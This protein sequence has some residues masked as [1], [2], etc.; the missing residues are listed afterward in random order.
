MATK[1]DYYEVLGVSRDATE[2]P[3]NIFALSGRAGCVFEAID[4][5][6]VHRKSASTSGALSHRVRVCNFINQAQLTN[7]FGPVFSFFCNVTGAL[8]ETGATRRR[9]D[10]VANLLR[11]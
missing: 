1:R 11:Y 10:G 9:R 5:A 7:W 4:I 8:C 2:D 3:H 6:S